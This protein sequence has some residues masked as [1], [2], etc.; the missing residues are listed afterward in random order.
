MTS[1]RQWIGSFKFSREESTLTLV[2]FIIFVIYLIYKDFKWFNWQSWL[3]VTFRTQ[4]HVQRP[5]LRSIIH[6]PNPTSTRPTESNQR[7]RIE[8]HGESQSTRQHAPWRKS[9]KSGLF[10][11]ELLGLYLHVG[12]Y[13]PPWFANSFNFLNFFYFFACLINL[14]FS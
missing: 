12:D 3:V 4:V 6:L 13:N 2:L 14:I 11:P 7:P 8:I 10:G 5:C 9:M 1:W